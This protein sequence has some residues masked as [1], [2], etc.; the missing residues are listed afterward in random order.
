MQEEV[1]NGKI[2]SSEWWSGKNIRLVKSYYGK[3]T[4]GMML[5]A[6]KFRLT[7]SGYTY[8]DFWYMKR[9][10]KTLCVYSG[11]MVQW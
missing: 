7:N 1:K 11:N 3:A 9:K 10:F 5:N 4:N 8:K 2:V 6:N